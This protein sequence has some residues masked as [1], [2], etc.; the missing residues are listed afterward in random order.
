MIRSQCVQ[1]IGINTKYKFQVYTCVYILYINV[2]GPLIV[3]ASTTRFEVWFQY[4]CNNKRLCTSATTTI[5]Y[6]WITHVISFTL[7]P[8]YV[9]ASRSEHMS[10]PGFPGHQ[11]KSRR[12]IY[13]WVTRSITL[14]YSPK[15]AA[16]RKSVIRCANVHYL[17]NRFNWDPTLVW[18]CIRIRFHHDG[19][20]ETKRITN[21]VN[22]GNGDPASMDGQEDGT[23]RMVDDLYMQ[24]DDPYEHHP[25]PRFDSVVSLSKQTMSKCSRADYPAP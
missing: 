18:I 2:N 14:R 6:L 16:H 17:R 19:R 9:C 1:L 5:N 3:I 15:P 7:I 25:P 13:E 21:G 4:K 22:F 8:Q 11:I 10:G 23:T 20:V 24:M 12:V